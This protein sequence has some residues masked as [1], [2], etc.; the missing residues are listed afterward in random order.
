MSIQL[1]QQVLVML[2]K[3]AQLE[4]ANTDKEERLQVLEAK[5]KQAKTLSLPKNG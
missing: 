5:V 1:Q 3:I 2:E 4:A